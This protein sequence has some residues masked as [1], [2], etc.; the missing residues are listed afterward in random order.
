MFT[1][2]SDGIPDNPRSIL[3]PVGGTNYAA[4]F[5]QTATLTVV[6]N[7][8]NGGMVGG[9][10]TYPVGSSQSISAAATNG[11][12]FAGW[13]DGNSDNPRTVLVPGGGAGYTATF[14]L[15]VQRA[16]L[17]AALSGTNLTVSIRFTG[18]PGVA[19]IFQS[20]S[21]LETW[22]DFQTVTLGD[23]GTA[24]TSIDTAGLSTRF[25]RVIHRE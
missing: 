24:A 12:T 16:S 23:D 21:D 14:Q 1:G 22:Q 17:G 19:Y 7:P 13:S 25:F 3:V 20:S 10:G 9:S 8:L 2:W 15:A 11:W 6:A 4:N 5:V 18:T